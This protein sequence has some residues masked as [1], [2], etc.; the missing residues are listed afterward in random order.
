MVAADDS[1]ELFFPMTIFL[2]PNNNKKILKQCAPTINRVFSHSLSIFPP[3]FYWKKVTRAKE[4][5]ILAVIPGIHFPAIPV[6]GC[7]TQLPFR[8]CCGPGLR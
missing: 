6:M 1:S 2:I 7:F 5:Q 8:I 3:S 4:E